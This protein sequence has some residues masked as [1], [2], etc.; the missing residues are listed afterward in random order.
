MRMLPV[1]LTQDYVSVDPLG[2]TIEAIE[3]TGGAFEGSWDVSVILGDVRIWTDHHDYGMDASSVATI[4][5]QDFAMALR[6]VL[7]REPS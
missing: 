1:E 7:S 3:N 4:A 6:D 5:A 2:F